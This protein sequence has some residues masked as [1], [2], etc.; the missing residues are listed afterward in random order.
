MNLFSIKEPVIDPTTG[1]L[2]KIIWQLSWPMLL[3]MIFNFLV[4]LTDIYVA[5][6]ISPQIQAAIGF[7]GHLYFLLV[8]VANAAGIGTVALISRSTGR[9]DFSETLKSAEQSLLLAAA[10]ALLLSIAVLALSSQIVAAVGVPLKIRDIAE[11]FLRIYAFSLGPNYLLIVSNAVFRAGGE[12]RKPLVTMFVVCFFNVLGDFG[13][14]MGIPPFPKMGFPGIAVSTAAS[15]TLGMLINFTFLY[16]SRW[17]PLLISSCTVSPAILKKIIKIS[18]PSALLQVSWNAGSIFLYN[19]LGRL[20]D[21]SIIALAS[22]TNGLRIEA[23]IFLPAF[24]LHMAGSVLVGQ[25]LG[26]GRSDRAAKV[27]WKIALAGVVLMSSIALVIFFGAEYFASLIA[28]EEDVWEE[29]VR[30]LKINMLSEPFM[31]LSMVL[32][33]CLQGAGDT[34][35]AMWVIITGMWLIRLPLA[36]LFSLVLG[37]GAIGV[38]VAMVISMVVQGLLM[39]Q[40]FQGGDWK[41][42]KIE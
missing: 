17:R 30:Y 23:I 29:T 33:G 38:W 22:I 20:G 27:G 42:L 7:I 25:N 9:K 35:G 12:I 4:G 5:G 32:G 40:R 1:N 10:I 18:W 19:I 41:K 37:F 6:L 16:F 31:A 34:R 15:V 13:L 28:K 11:T 8:I 26:A 21:T 24:A 14:V 3:I 2:W 36:F 39:T